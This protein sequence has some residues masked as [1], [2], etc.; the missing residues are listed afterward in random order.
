MPIQTK[1][2]ERP[3]DRDPRAEDLLVRFASD[4]YVMTIEPIPQHPRHTVLLALRSQELRQGPVVVRDQGVDITYRKLLAL[5]PEDAEVLVQQ[6]QKV[7][8]PPTGND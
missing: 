7:L 3:P 5:R 4:P 6:L 1:Y 2:D 8:A